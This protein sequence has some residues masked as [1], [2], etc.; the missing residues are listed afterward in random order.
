MKVVLPLLY[1]VFIVSVLSCKRNTIPRSSPFA[2]F[3]KEYTDSVSFI[4]IGDWGQ[5]G[6]KFQK[7]VANQMDIQAIKFNTQFIITTGDNFY[8]EGVKDV[9]DPHWQKSF[10]NIYN[11][12]GHQ[13]PWYPVLGNHDYGANPQAQVEFSKKDKR[14]KMPSRYYHVNKS[15]GDSLN[16][17]FVFTDTSPFL[18]GY[19]RRDRGDIRMQDTAAQLKWMKNLLSTSNDK[20]KIVIGHHPIYSAGSHGRTITL[21]NLFKPAFLQNKVDF[22]ISGHDHSLQYLKVKNQP[23]HYLVSGGGSSNTSIYKRGFNVFAKSTTGFLVMTLYAT[24]ARFYF[25]DQDGNTV[26]SHQVIKS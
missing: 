19:H 22:F 2:K 21:L 11:G 7:V 5:E 25:I 4:V 6:S 8:P 1:V 14:W 23:I 10:N 16:A 9:D 12:K 17:L 13:V 24:K 3:Q 20:W 18:R 15:L 26:Y